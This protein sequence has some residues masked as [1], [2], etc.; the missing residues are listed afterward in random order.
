MEGE[1][2]F[3]ILFWG[4]EVKIFEIVGTVIG[5]RAANERSVSSVKQS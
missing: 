4:I 5:N 2:R 1:R 3:V